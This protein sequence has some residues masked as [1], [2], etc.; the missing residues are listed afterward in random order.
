MQELREGESCGGR[1]EHDTDCIRSTGNVE[2][3]ANARVG[4]AARDRIWFAPPT[5]SR[6]ETVR[7]DENKELGSS[8][9]RPPL[10]KLGNALLD[11]GLTPSFLY[12]AHEPPGW[13]AGT[14]RRDPHVSSD[15]TALASS[16]ACVS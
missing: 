6:A 8:E 4:P 14:A 2:A 12:E 7:K 16:F 5:R 15:R 11:G 3:A 13:W 9:R 10:G 1:A